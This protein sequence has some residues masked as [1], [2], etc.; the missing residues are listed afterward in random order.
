MKSTS[1]PEPDQLKGFMLGE[2]S[3]PEL[4]VLGEHISTCKKCTDTIAGLDADDTLHSQLRD[5]AAKVEMF[6]SEVDSEAMQR[7]K[8]LPA[9][10]P[11]PGGMA[12]PSSKAPEAVEATLGKQ[13]G[14]DEDIREVTSFL[15]PP[16]QADEIGRLGPYRVLK[17]LGRGGMGVVF[18]AEDPRLKRMCAIKAMLPEVAGKPAMKER[19]LR[20]AQAAATVEHDHIV[21]IYQVD[22]DR[23]L[24]YIAMP[25]LQGMSL[26]DW[27]N[28]KGNAGE[29]SLTGEESSGFALENKA[30]PSM[31]MPTVQALKVGREIA[32]GLQAAHDR[33]LIHRD[34]KP[35]NIWLDANA[36]GRVKILDFGLA[37]VPSEG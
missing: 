31:P 12:K 28:R 22:E 23:G 35:A 16:Q 6:M 18:Q 25:F 20:E 27:L 26:E 14:A 19:F 10:A 33:G 7:I 36:G 34:I 8:E 30:R 29:S 9:P 32:G 15:A 17:V 13:P 11:S 4:S 3:E 2:L 24:P 5:G 37:L 1:C 21:P